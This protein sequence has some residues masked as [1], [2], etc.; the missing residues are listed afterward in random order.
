[1]HASSS[2]ESY[3]NHVRVADQLLDIARKVQELSFSKEFNVLK[4]DLFN[5]RSN[6]S[7]VFNLSK[8]VLV[9]MHFADVFPKAIIIGDKGVTHLSQNGS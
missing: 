8:V 7:M 6:H 2:D 1:M 5:D 3:A 4:E 9:R